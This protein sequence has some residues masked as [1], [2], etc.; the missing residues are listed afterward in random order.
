MIKRKDDMIKKLS[1]VNM[2]LKILTDYN[3]KLNFLRQ[4]GHGNVED[5]KVFEGSPDC[6]SQKL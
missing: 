6:L 3:T 4:C 1:L 2:S 5:L